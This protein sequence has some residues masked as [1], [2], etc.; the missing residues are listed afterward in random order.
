MTHILT[1]PM[2]PG[3]TVG[4]MTC[5]G[6]S[7]LACDRVGGRTTGEPDA[8]PGIGLDSD[9][10]VDPGSTGQGIKRV[11]CQTIVCISK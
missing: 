9:I 5:D 8:S 6:V 1:R 10:G 11:G 7:D 2:E 4:E 3:V